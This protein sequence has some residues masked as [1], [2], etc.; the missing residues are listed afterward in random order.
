MKKELY[1]KS[2]RENTK[3]ILI[4]P[5]IVSLVFASLFFGCMYFNEYP[6]YGNALG[7][8]LSVFVLLFGYMGVRPF[9]KGYHFL[10]IQE[11]ALNV[12]Y[13]NRND[14]LK[15]D[16]EREW[17]VSKTGP[18]IVYLNRKFID[19]LV[20]VEEIDRGGSKQ[21][22]LAIEITF[23]DINGN[24]QSFFIDRNKQELRKFRLWLDA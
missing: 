10:R 21:S 22:V 18:W 3:E 7:L 17:F 2:V 8:G 16:I 1:E 4:A 13:S 14:F 9:Y 20:N 19:H 24:I 12:L 23:M 11:K 15:K 5:M 6:K